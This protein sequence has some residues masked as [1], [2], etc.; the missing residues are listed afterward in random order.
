MECPTSLGPASTNAGTGT[1]PTRAEA[2]LKGKISEH[3]A[4]QV[5]VGDTELCNSSYS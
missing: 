2:I 5:N 4:R 3:A 1:C